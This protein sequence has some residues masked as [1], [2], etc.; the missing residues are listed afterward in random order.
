MNN[1]IKKALPII[2][3]TLMFSSCGKVLGTENQFGQTVFLFSVIGM[4]MALAVTKL[5]KGFDVII[6]YSPANI[7]S[8]FFTTSRWQ[9]RLLWGVSLALLVFQ[10][11][12]GMRLALGRSTEL[13]FFMYYLV[14]AGLVYGM[15]V[16]VFPEN[17]EN[18]FVKETERE[19]EKYWSKSLISRLYKLYIIYAVYL[20]ITIPMSFVFWKEYHPEDNTFWLRDGNIFGILLKGIAFLILVMALKLKFKQG[21]N[22]KSEQIHDSTRKEDNGKELVLTIDYCVI[23]I[24]ILIHFYYIIIR[25][26]GLW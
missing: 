23:W 24:S 7:K 4:V 9:M 8:A 20:F 6:K 14:L 22:K 13:F 15:V 16:Y 3:L 10:L 25:T 17:L 5:V 19:H 11:V 12:W 21:K 18:V 2:A 1:E 26:S